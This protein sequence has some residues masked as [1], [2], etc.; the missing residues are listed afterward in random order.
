MDRNREKGILLGTLAE[1]LQPSVPS[2]LS[3]CVCKLCPV[4]PDPDL[5]DLLEKMPSLP[6][7]WKV[8]SVYPV[9]NWGLSNRKL[10][11][12][13]LGQSEG[14]SCFAHQTGSFR[15]IMLTPQW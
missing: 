5:M 10:P 9:L 12:S 6:S 4:S 11:A 8:Q 2:H 7:D 3:L 14:R 15:R 1:V 13:G